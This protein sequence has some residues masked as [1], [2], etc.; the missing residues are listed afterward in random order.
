MEIAND[1]IFFK[2]CKSLEKDFYYKIYIYDLILLFFNYSL[3]IKI[4]F[5]YKKLKI[6][7]I[8]KMNKQTKF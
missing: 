5:S 8:L 6:F 1:K 7:I 2:F 4:D 3:W